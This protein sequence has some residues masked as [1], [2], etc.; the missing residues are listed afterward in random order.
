MNKERLKKLESVSLELIIDTLNPMLKEIES[1][2]WLINITWTKISPD[3]SYLDVYVSSFKNE[4]ILCKT[5]A[6]Y[7]HLIQR[8]IGKKLSLRKNPRVRFRYDNKWK[9]AQE[10]SM[11]INNLDY[12]E[13]NND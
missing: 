13:I 8:N 10:I 7:A 11:T 1:D 4:D 6:N 2:F 12:K 3:L 9:I 5:L